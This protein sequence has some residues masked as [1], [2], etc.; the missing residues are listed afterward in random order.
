M[1]QIR[2]EDWFVT[3]DLK[4]AYF[5]ISILP[6][7]RKF[8]R[9][10]FGGK[11]YQYRVLPF[12]LALSP[13]TFT[14]CVDAA[15]V[16]LRL[17]GIRIMNYIDDWLI[18]AQSHQLAVRHRDVVLAHM[19]K[20]GLR[21]NAKKSV[22]SPLQRTT[23]LGVIWDSTSMQGAPVTGTYRV[24]PIGCEKNKARP[25]T[26]CQTVSETVGSYGSSIQRDTCWTVAHETP[27]VVAQDQ[28]V[29]PEGQ[30][31]SHDQ[32]HAAMPSCLGNVEETLGSCP[33]VPCWELHVVA[34]ANDRCFSHGLGA[35]LE[36]TLRSRSVEGPSSLM[37]HQPSGD[38]GCVLAL[39]NFL[40]DL[41][42]HHVLVRS[43]NTS[44]GL[45]HKS[46]GGFAV[47]STVQTGVPNPPVVPREVVVSASNLHPWGPQYRSRPSCR[48]Q[49][50]RPG[51]WRLHPEVVELIWKKFGQAQV[52][53]F[54]S[55][56]T[57]H[58]PLW[59]SLTH[60]A[61]LG[62]DAI[63]TDVAE[64]S[65]VCISP[66][67]S[68][69]RSTGESSPGP[70]PTTSY[71]PA[72]AGQSMVSQIYSPFSTGLLWSSPSGGTFCPKRGARYFTPL[73]NYGNCGLG[74]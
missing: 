23:F 59:F 33:R 56:E 24:H 43:D 10:A 16:P 28:R 29:F 46:P 66:D 19:E 32:G 31:L 47:T 53:L 62:L 57:S 64:A 17:Q 48:G 21:L 37:A 8:L 1:S 15:L 71:C 13:R 58:C 45:L 49:G 51:E 50:L 74:L 26:H 68:A 41:R 40:A 34:D 27:P 6:Y 73:Q 4:D 61:P 67:C 52:D 25:V 42:G 72:V 54:A 20:L 7:H 38:V 35:I 9:F 18:L 60:P 3:I 22:L 2:S 70:G 36:G 44:V 69:P 63:D 30:P 39:K 14:K 55:R 5:H 11:A 65:S 12:G